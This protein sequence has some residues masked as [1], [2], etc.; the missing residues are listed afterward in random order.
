MASVL[1]RD[2]VV[3][4]SRWDAEAA[5]QAL[6]LIREGQHEEQR[7]HR[8]EELRALHEERKNALYNAAYDRLDAV[9]VDSLFQYCVN[10]VDYTA[11]L[12]ITA[13]TLLAA[14][15]NLSGFKGE[16]GVKSLW[17]WLVKIAQN[18]CYK[19]LQ[20]RQREIQHEKTLETVAASSPTPHGTRQRLRRSRTIYYGRWENTDAVKRDIAKL[21]NEDDRILL[22]MDM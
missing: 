15:E 16:H 11:A 4:E 3:S 21:K 12:D 13:Q 2:K 20:R 8:H 22:K 1:G 18:F 5:E 17:R 9:F 6:Q 7:A 19:E 14:R 10:M